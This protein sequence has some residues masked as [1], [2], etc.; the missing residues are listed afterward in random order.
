M[1]QRSCENSSL[2]Q[3]PEIS[4]VGAGDP[5]SPAVKNPIYAFPPA[6]TRHNVTYSPYVFADNVL[7]PHGRGKPLPYSIS[8]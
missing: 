8:R 3:K 1:M 2:L 4:T 5:G 7:F 6:N